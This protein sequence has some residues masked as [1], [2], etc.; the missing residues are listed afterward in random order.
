MVFGNLYNV[1]YVYYSLVLLR[2]F[3]CFLDFGGQLCIVSLRFN[4]VLKGVCSTR[5]NVI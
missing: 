1:L 4:A 5:A 2:P 3:L